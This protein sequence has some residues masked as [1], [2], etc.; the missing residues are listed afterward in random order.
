MYLQN[1]TN[2]FRKVR[3]QLTNQRQ[4]P[5]IFEDSEESA[6]MLNPSLNSCSSG[7]NQSTAAQCLINA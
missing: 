6:A 4:A 3:V 1:K 7:R 2:I 5:G